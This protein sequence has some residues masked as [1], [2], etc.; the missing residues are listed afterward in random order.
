L[1]YLI[2][3]N[4][5]VDVPLSLLGQLLVV[6]QIFHSSLLFHSLL[7]FETPSATLK[8]SPTKKMDSLLLALRNPNLSDPFHESDA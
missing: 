3:T 8:F 6:Q 1:V 7:D 2:L 5:P 4:R